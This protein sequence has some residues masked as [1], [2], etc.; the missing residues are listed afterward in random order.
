VLHLREE[1]DVAP[2]GSG[3]RTFNYLQF[4]FSVTLALA[5]AT[6]WSL[7]SRRR[8]VSVR[9]YDGLRVLLRYLLADYMLIYGL[10]KV[11]KTQFPSPLLRTEVLMEPFGEASPM[12]ILWTFIKY[13]IPY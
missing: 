4:A 1:I 7:A 8:T 9:I 2:N 6:G 12:G 5:I 13:S 3:D 10:G 11:L